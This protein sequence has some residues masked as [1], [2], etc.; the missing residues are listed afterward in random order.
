MPKTWH[1]RQKQIRNLRFS[2]ISAATTATIVK[3]NE[4][5]FIKEKNS[6]YYYEPNGG[7]LV[8]NWDT[9]LSTGN[10]WNT[11]W[12]KLYPS[13]SRKVSITANVP[14]TITHNLNTPNVHV[15]VVRDWDAVDVEVYWFTDDTLFIRTDV[16]W[17]Y[18]VM[19]TKVERLTNYIYVSIDNGIRRINPDTLQLFDTIS[20]PWTDM[21]AVTWFDWFIYA[22]DQSWTSN[23]YKINPDTGLVVGTLNIPGAQ[24][25]PIRN[26]WTFLYVVDWGGSRVCKINPSW[27]M[28][29]VSTMTTGWAWARTL[30]IDLDLNRDLWYVTN[31]I[32]GTGN[33]VEEFT[34]STMA[35]TGRSIAYTTNRLW[36]CVLIGTDLFVS[37]I[38][39]STDWIYKI[40]TVT[41]T[42]TSFTP[43]GNGCGHPKLYQ[44]NIY[45]NVYSSNKVS[46]LNPASLVVTDTPAIT[47]P[48]TVWMYAGK[49]YAVWYT[50]GILTEFD[51]NTM[52]LTWRTISWNT[53]PL[54]CEV[55]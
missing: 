16:T 24:F 17:T 28:S 41:M 39:Y 29:L 37:R 32:N 6:H 13:V 44:W 55:L 50:T 35:L 34:I 31:Y 46:R 38:N 49:W 5:C 51:A 18:E 22:W 20:I 3:P 23:F 21:S 1:A 10:G 26:D 25:G 52:S 15:S 27:S 19:V 4:V 33:T 30:W 8:V 2:T 43:I 48:R 40:N 47:G 12:F 54:W 45:V 11:R 9:I 36:G 42:Q 7:H 53:W 14:K